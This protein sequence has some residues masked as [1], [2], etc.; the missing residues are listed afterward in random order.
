[1][2]HC[3][4]NKDCIDYSDFKKDY[5]DLAKTVNRRNLLFFAEG[6]SASGGNL[7]N[8]TFI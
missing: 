5:S 7:R 4:I 6:E 3:K 2:M 8:H 1:M